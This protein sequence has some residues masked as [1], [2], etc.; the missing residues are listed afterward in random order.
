MNGSERT[1]IG[2]GQ[3]TG[4]TIKPMG[5]PVCLR[6]MRYLRDLRL[7]VEIALAEVLRRG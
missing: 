7:E 4:Y 6:C 3:A 2:C 1:C 5:I